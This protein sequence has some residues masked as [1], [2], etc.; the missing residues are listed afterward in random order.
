MFGT[1]FDPPI[2]ATVQPMI[3]IIVA[4]IAIQSVI[5]L[6]ADWNRTPGDK[7]VAGD[8]DEDELAAIKRSVGES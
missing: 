7:T 5:N 3:L 4:L 2:P 6:F 8:L 1:A